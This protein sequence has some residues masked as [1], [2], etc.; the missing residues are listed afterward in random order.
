MILG[1]S[2]RHSERTTPI[3]TM[4]LVPGLVALW[5]LSTAAA[6]CRN[7]RQDAG[8]AGQRHNPACAQASMQMMSC[9]STKST[10]SVS[11]QQSPTLQ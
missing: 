4:E 9:Q 6:I 3:T 1:P 7:P 5:L 2:Q 8:A 11:E 10:G